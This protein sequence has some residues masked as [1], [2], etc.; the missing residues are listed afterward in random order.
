MLIT[1]FK[2]STYCI[3]SQSR[4]KKEAGSLTVTG[5]VIAVMSNP[6]AL[7]KTFKSEFRLENTFSNP[8]LFSLETSSL[9]PSSITT[10]STVPLGFTTSIPSFFE[11]FR[12]LLFES[13][14]EA[15]FFDFFDR[16]LLEGSSIRMKR[17][18]ETPLGTLWKRNSLNIVECSLVFR[19]LLPFTF[20]EESNSSSKFS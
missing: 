6:I 17:P 14:E 1:L 15:F 18:R 19:A 9:L 2:R 12:D 3:C 20:G 16:D 8:C 13:F 11:P 5:S 7:D 10:S 4:I